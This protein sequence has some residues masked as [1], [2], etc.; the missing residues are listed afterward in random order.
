MKN[1]IT[2]ILCLFSFTLLSQVEFKKHY[3]NTNLLSIANLYYSS[4]TLGYEYRPI[5]QFGIEATFGHIISNKEY[6][7]SD[8]IDKF[9]GKGAVYR[10]EPK[11]YIWT[12]Q[13]DEEVRSFFIS[14]KV[15]KTDNKFLSVRMKNLNDYEDLASYNVAQKIKGIIPTFGF[16]IVTHSHFWV[17]TSVGFGKRWI[18]TKNDYEGEIEDLLSIWRPT[19]DLEGNGEL[20]KWRINLN[21]KMGVAF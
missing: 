5:K 3:V 20:I 10:I 2:I 9:N 11:V 17:E 19:A 12:G 15:Y 16:N 14:M 6:N 18:S 1:I 21:F 7:E 4:I 13:I 8:I